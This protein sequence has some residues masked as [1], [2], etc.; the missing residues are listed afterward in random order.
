MLAAVEPLPCPAENPVIS[1]LTKE[2]MATASEQRRNRRFPLFRSAL[3]EVHNR[4]HRDQVRG[5]I[6]D[7]SPIGLGLLHSKPVELGPATLT[8]QDADGGTVSVRMQIAWCTSWTGDWYLSGG[9][10]NE[11]SDKRA[12]RL[13]LSTADREATRRLANRHSY[14]RPALI[15]H[16]R[17][18]ST[19]WGFTR[20]ISNRGIGLIHEVPLETERALVTVSAVS[21]QPIELRIDVKWCKRCADGWYVSG[22]EF[23]PLRAERLPN[24]WL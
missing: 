24:R 19:S 4:N 22:G 12:M 20:D 16:N 11:S 6:R 15:R 1:E 18:R 21:G 23:V 14:F 10:V 5:Y 2:A 17:G 8:A 13:L 9:K 3:I 7:I